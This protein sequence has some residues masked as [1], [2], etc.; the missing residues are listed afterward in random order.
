MFIPD[1]KGAAS[2]CTEAASARTVRG[3]IL[4]AALAA[5]AVVPVAAA[6]ADEP[7]AALPAPESFAVHGQLTY[8]EQES[9]AFN[10]PYR[11]PN[12]LSPDEGR[13]TFD[14]TLYI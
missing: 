10:A 6:L 12:S 14:A 4:V 7:A 1:A 5:A 2:R 9:N 13:E 3:C 11:G 8:V